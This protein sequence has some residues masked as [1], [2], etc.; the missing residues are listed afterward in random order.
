MKRQL[1][2]E[3]REYAFKLKS[4]NSEFQGLSLDLSG[5]L[6]KCGIIA[7]ANDVRKIDINCMMNVVNCVLK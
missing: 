2:T 3:L 4:S 6:T 5:R 7:E 1:E